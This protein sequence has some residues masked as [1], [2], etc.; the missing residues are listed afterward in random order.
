MKRLVLSVLIV[1]LFFC[2][3]GCSTGTSVQSNSSAQ[4]ITKENAS[5]E[6]QF[7]GS[8]NSNKYHYP[9]C[10]WAQRIYP[11]NEI[12]FSNPQDARAGGYVPCK[13]CAPPE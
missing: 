10:R 11:E 3:I 1:A 9:S 8:I 7:V 2:I 13:V 6:Q 12:W 5:A 4:S